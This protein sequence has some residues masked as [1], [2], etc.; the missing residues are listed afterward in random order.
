M[1]LSFVA[2][3]GYEDQG[4]RLDDVLFSPDNYVSCVYTWDW[5]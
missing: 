2:H 5:N 4:D 3:P 1:F